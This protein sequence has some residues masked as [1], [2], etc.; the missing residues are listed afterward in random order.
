MI[1]SGVTFVYVCAIIN[2]AISHSRRRSVGRR[3][4]RC[5]LIVLFCLADWLSGL[6][7]T[8]QNFCQKAGPVAFDKA[9]KEGIALYVI[10]L[11]LLFR[12]GVLCLTH[13]VCVVIESLFVFLVV[14]RI[15]P[16]T[17]PRGD[18]VPNDDNYDLGQGA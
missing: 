5:I 11:L 15:M 2:S 7:C 14:D 18:G 16:D 4:R 13:C 17:S 1:V 9:E 12:F 6:T 8:D 3:C 10:V